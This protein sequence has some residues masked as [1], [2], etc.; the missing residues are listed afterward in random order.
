MAGFCDQ[1]NYE[2]H[3]DNPAKMYKMQLALKRVN[4]RT[5]SVNQNK[6]N[7]PQNLQFKAQINL[8]INACNF[9]SRLRKGYHQNKWSVMKAKWIIIL[10]HGYFVVF[11][12]FYH[13]TAKLNGMW[14]LST[15]WH[16]HLLTM[17]KCSRPDPI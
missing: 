8:D 6:S 12:F 4:L 13:L 7:S 1:S 10:V 5:K 15:I 2:P 9:E 3:P 14:V 16:F 17:V 11:C